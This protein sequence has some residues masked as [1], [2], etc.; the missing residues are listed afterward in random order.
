LLKRPAWVFADEATSALDD[1][2]QAAVYGKLVAMTTER[3]GGMVSIAHREGLAAF[4]TRSW[5]LAPVTGGVGFVL[6][7]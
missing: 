5:V 3:G 4:H 7:G 1:A 6:S 2:A